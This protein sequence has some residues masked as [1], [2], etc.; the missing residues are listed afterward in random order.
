MPE[1]MLNGL[2]QCL[3]LMNLICMIGGLF[4]G[5]FFGALPGFTATMAVSVFV[6]FSFWLAPDSALLLLSGLFCGAI[7]GGGITAILLGIPGTP[8]SL[9]TT[10]D[11]VPMVKRGETGRALGVITFCSS[12]GGFISALAL[13]FGAPLLAI[14][15]LKVGPPEQF[16]L[17]VFGL[18]V[19][20]ILTKG[21]MLKGFIVGAF[22][23]ILA[24]V[25]QDP[26][27]AYPRMTFGIHEI[28][29]GLPLIPILIGVFSLPEVFRMIETGINERRSVT[30]SIGRLLIALKD[31]RL[32]ISNT[33]RSAAI[34]VGIGIVPAAGPD[35]ASFIA[36]NQAI[37]S[38]KEPKTFG[39]GNIQGIVASETANSACTGGSLIPLLTLGIPGSAPAALY[40]G[41][42][43]IHGLR[44]GAQLFTDNANVTYALLMGFCLINIMQ[45]FMGL[46]FCRIA[47][48][49]VTI[50]SVILVPCILILTMVGAYAIQQSVLDIWIMFIS[51]V[52]GF[53]LTKYGFPI[54]PVAL[55]LILGPIM[56]QSF[57]LT[58]IM[59]HGN[60]LLILTRPLAIVFFA[61][62][63]F[64]ILW[65]FISGKIFKGKS[66]EAPVA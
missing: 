2:V 27:H 53:F 6:P 11:G 66:M 37:A 21:N 19:V 16:A 34:G 10:F 51:G 20:C 44:P 22:T 12:M 43:Y 38:S 3:S 1:L 59:F 62:T 40:L 46:F 35:I 26:I 55:G 45:Y 29:T 56:E 49:V 52:I 15:A 50:S 25:G 4:I 32:I 64:S 48:K 39:K 17:T 63:I 28:I 9:P 7:Y 65:P 42:L 41:A 58:M 47:S 31:I 57:G 30:T 14:I 36:Y 8:A 13:L 33:L 60:F 23:L 54:S 5:I 61:L 24:C 18:S